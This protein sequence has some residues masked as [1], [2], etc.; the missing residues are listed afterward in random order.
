MLFLLG[1]VPTEGFPERVPG[2]KDETT[3]AKVRQST[4]PDIGIPPF[5]QVMKGPVS[6]DGKER[7]SVRH[8]IAELELNGLL[9]SNR[10]VESFGGLWSCSGMV[11]RESLLARETTVRSYSTL[12][13]PVAWDPSSV[14]TSMSL[15]L[16]VWW[17][18]GSSLTRVP[19]MEA[20]A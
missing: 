19:G 5:P 2:A 18:R 11:A 15:R 10:R 6:L 20:R 9:L 7:D 3:R 14:M 12:A 13:N 17:P 1:R 4:R 16:L 8:P